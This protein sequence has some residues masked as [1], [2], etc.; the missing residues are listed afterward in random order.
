MFPQLL[1]Q[2]RSPKF[3][4]LPQIFALIKTKYIL[5]QQIQVYFQLQILQCQ[6]RSQVYQ[7]PDSNSQWMQKYGYV[8]NFSRIYAGLLLNPHKLFVEIFFVNV[9]ARKYTYFTLSVGHAFKKL[10]RKIIHAGPIFPYIK[11]IECSMHTCMYV[12]DVYECSEQYTKWKAL[13]TRTKKIPFDSFE[14]PLYSV[15]IQQ[16]KQK[17]HVEFS[18]EE[19]NI[20][21]FHRCSCIFRVYAWLLLLCVYC[22]RMKWKVCYFLFTHTQNLYSVLCKYSMDQ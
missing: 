3:K 17:S 16:F 8:L 15:S 11:N 19:K 18:A 21:I 2:I 9:F 20:F 4:K 10:H 12:I 1:W 22:T 13:A 6:S 7:D 5:Y 14:R